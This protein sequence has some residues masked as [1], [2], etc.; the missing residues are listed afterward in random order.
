MF[1]KVCLTDETV[2]GKVDVVNLCFSSGGAVKYIVVFGSVEKGPLYTVHQIRC[3]SLLGQAVARFTFMMDTGVS[4][5]SRL[6]VVP[7]WRNKWKTLG[8]MFSVSVYKQLSIRGQS[9]PVLW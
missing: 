6:R 4:C 8:R 5:C 3:M 2:L 7:F 9:A 1:G